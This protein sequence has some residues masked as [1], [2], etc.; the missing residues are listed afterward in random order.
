MCKI[1]QHLTG[2][3]V[4]NQKQSPGTLTQPSMIIR[5][6]RL[7]MALVAVHWPFTSLASAPTPGFRRGDQR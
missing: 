5:A 1:L 2:L 6:L 3:T 4:T 7:M